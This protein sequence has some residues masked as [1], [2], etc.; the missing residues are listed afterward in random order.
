MLGSYNPSVLCTVRV[1][2]LRRSVPASPDLHHAV[3]TAQ[4][5][6]HNPS[7][8]DMFDLSRNGLDQSMSC[9]VR[10]C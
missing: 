1:V 4:S 10:I 9:C 3:F 8:A 5:S 6:A 2:L 7:N